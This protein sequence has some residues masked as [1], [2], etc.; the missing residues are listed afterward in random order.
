MEKSSVLFLLTPKTQVACLKTEMNV[1]Q[2]LEK[3]K[4]H[5]YSAIPM[6]DDEGHYV[7]TISE[8]DLLWQIIKEEDVSP[9]K[10]EK[11]E[12]REAGHPLPDDNSVKAASD[13]LVTC[14]LPEWMKS[15]G[16]IL[17]H[18]GEDEEQEVEE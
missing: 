2:A 14:K 16:N 11:I 4:A 18:W 13:A 15:I 6:I 3:M 8:G 1:R 9:E 12:N 17:A 5:G 7:A 10:L